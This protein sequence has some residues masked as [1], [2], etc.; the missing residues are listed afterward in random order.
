MPEQISK[1]EFASRMKESRERLFT[2]A[3]DQILKTIETPQS[4][5][6]FLSIIGKTDYTITN[7]LLVHA[8]KNS[9]TKLK[10]ISHWR[11]EGLYIK[12]G[13]KG[14]QILEP[15][16]YIRSDGT[17]GVSYNVKSV[18][19]LSQTNFKGDIPQKTTRDVI[20]AITYKAEIRPEIVAD[21]SKMPR[22]VYYDQGYDSIL[23][24]PGLDENTMIQGLIHE[25]A[26]I[27]CKDSFSNYKEAQFQVGSISA[28]ISSRYGL[29]FDESFAERC[30]DT[31]KD[32]DEKMIKR[33]FGEMQ[34]HAKAVTDRMD[35]WFY[36]KEN[37]RNNEAR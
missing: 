23:V 9:V 10:D 2:M 14:I 18:F 1:E 21:N 20:S 26:F 36:G 12:K 3:N 15:K 24:L 22:P 31:F 30:M 6:N 19:D 11:E 29:K 34:N 4:Y 32:L 27:E 13:E 25:Y 5:L 37:N 8:Q 7:A 17:E 16:T 35:R 33:E 28:I